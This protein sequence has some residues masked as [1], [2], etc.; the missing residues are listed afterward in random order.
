MVRGMSD[1][2]LPISAGR[3]PATARRPLPI[4]SSLVDRASAIVAA[5]PCEGWDDEE[6]VLRTALRLGLSEL[7]R[8][9]GLKTPNQLAGGD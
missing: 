7:E 2:T 3:H 5:Q 4:R 8:L 9:A 1:T 6:E